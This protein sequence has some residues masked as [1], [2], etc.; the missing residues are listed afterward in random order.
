MKPILLVLL[1]SVITVQVS[2]AQITRNDVLPLFAKLGAEDFKGAQ[3]LSAELLKEFK[4][5][6]TS[7]V[8]IVRYAYLY[9]SA[10]LVS[11]GEMS[12]KELKSRSKAVRGKFLLMPGH[13]ATTD[14]VKLKYDSNEL[15]MQGDQAKCSVITPNSNQSSIYFFEYY[16]L[17]PGTD[18]HQFDGKDTRIGGTL[19][20]IEFNP[21]GSTIWIMRLHFKDAILR[22]M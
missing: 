4:K 8:G 12:Y 3:Q 6:T 22:E 11:K 14:T 13:P 9:S 7:L 1:T 19:D 16:D 18:I 15:K 2:L 21:N 5:D 17:V 20:S 10:A